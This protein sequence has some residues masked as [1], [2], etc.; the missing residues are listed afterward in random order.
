[1]TAREVSEARMRKAVLMTRPYRADMSVM[2]IAA[3]AVALLLISAPAAAA[4]PRFA[5]FD[6]QSDLSAA[7]R[8]EYGGVTV[9]PLRSL[10]HVPGATLVRCATWCRFGKG[11]LAF[12]KPT[13]LSAGDVS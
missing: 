7:A 10:A 12:S 6:L 4:A 9:K 5:L 13:H 1:M 11:W 8:N 2:R 3:A